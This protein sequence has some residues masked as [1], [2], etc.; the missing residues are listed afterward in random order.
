M[1]PTRL[2]KC[3]LEVA[4]DKTHLLRFSRFHPSTKRRFTFL[5]FEFFWKRD[6]QGVPRVMRRTARTKLQAAC[7]RMKEWIKL[8]RHL[9]GREFFR[10]LN[11]R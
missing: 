7:R 5:G 9:P 10:R 6:R 4:P 2:E 3:N 1:L 11:A 8:N